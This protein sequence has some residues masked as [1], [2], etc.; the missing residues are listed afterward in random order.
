M[1]LY[2]K[3]VFSFTIII[4]G[5]YIIDLPVFIIRYEVYHSSQSASYH[6]Q[7]ASLLICAA[8]LMISSDMLNRLACR[9]AAQG[10]SFK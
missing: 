3:T 5:L 8:N 6:W 4:H 9:L 10:G 2:F 7:P 1:L